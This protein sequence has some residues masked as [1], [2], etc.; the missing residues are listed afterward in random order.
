MLVLAARMVLPLVIALREPIPQLELAVPMILLVVLVSR[1]RFLRVVLAARMVQPVQPMARRL[2][3]TVVELV[4]PVPMV[5]AVMILPEHLVVA[6]RTILRV[7][8]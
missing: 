4:V 7:V 3:L 5:V 8:K 2:A 6:E 1:I